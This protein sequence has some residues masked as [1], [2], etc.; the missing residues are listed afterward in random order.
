MT[1]SVS[2]NCECEDPEWCVENRFDV[3][4]RGR[5]NN[6]GI[7][8]DAT[9]CFG[10]I[11]GLRDLDF[12]LRYPECCI[13]EPWISVWHCEQLRHII[14]EEFDWVINNDVF[15]IDGIIEGW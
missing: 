2:G 13:Q 1:L 4:W 11:R 12:C 7:F 3:R 6:D 14:L 9:D 8:A 15:R 10:G 5:S